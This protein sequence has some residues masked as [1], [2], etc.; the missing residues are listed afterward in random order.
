MSDRGAIT[1]TERGFALFG[2]VED[3]RGNTALVQQSSSARGPHIWLFVRDPVS[4]EPG[5]AAVHLSLELAQELRDTIDAA[6]DYLRDR[7]T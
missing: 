7:G 6:I 1:F 3:A 5:F 2:E 4:Q